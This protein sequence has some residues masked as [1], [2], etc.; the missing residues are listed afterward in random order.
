MPI[1][2]ER[3]REVCKKRARSRSSHFLDIQ[4]GLFPHPVKIGDRSSGWPNY[5]TDAINAAR[6]AGKTKNEIRALVKKLEAARSIIAG[7]NGKE[8]QELV[9]QIYAGCSTSGE[10]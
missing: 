1:I 3:L 5:E 9:K 2:I 10:S 4:E 6:I 7:M 8:I